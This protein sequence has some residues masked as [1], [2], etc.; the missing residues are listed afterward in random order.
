MKSAIDDAFFAD[1]GD[2]IDRGRY[3][4]HGG[5]YTN[6]VTR[7]QV[8][9]TFA[10]GG[11][12]VS[13]TARAYRSP[14]DNYAYYYDGSEWRGTS[15]AAGFGCQNVSRPCSG[16][17]CDA[18]GGG[19]IVTRVCDGYYNNLLSSLVC[20]APGQLQMVRDNGSQI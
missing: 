4:G 9:A 12:S 7:D 15:A 17:A 1:T 3:G 19:P 13:Y 6:K 11:Y 16:K 18:T 10:P 5:V 8:C 14:G 20:T 2:R